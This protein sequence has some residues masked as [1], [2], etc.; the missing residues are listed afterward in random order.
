MMSVLQYRFLAQL[1]NSMSM[2]LKIREEEGLLEES[3]LLF[4]GKV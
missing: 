1:K 4:D 2:K 3:R